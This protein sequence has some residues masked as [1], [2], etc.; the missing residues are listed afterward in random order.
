MSQQL[1]LQQVTH[2]MPANLKGVVTQEYVDKINNMVQDPIVA[3]QVRENFISY[4]KVLADGKFKT[5]DYLNAVAY[6]SFKLMG[7]RNPDAYFRTFPDRHADLVA[8]GTSPKDIAAYVSAFNRG[9]LVNLIM[10]QTLVPTWVL[11]ADIHQRAINKL[12]DLM[13]NAQSEKVQSD[14]AN[15]LLTHLAKPK[16]AGPLINLNIGEPQGMKE[17]KDLM[18]QLAANQQAAIASGHVTAR[19]IAAQPLIRKDEDIIDV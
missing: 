9:K 19:D 13:M 14:S 6:V 12:A 7:M 16:D 5:Q 2:A 18:A 1:T 11:N 3:E 4:S 17:M 15:A 10:E 8:K